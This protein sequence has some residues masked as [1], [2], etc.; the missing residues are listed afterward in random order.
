MPGW[1]AAF[2]RNE[3]FFI[4]SRNMDEK[5]AL[6]EPWYWTDRILV[7]QLEREI[8]KEHGLYGKKLETLARRQDNDDVLFRV[9]RI[10]IR[11]V[12][13]LLNDCPRSH[14]RQQLVLATQARAG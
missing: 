10:L 13:Q 14:P 3:D 12:Q 5:V 9:D 11:T 2:L 6:P 7:T 1:C 8:S 4:P